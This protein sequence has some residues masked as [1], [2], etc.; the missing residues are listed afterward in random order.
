MTEHIGVGDVR[1]RAVALTGLDAASQF[2]GLCC[3]PRRAEV[4]VVVA[5]VADRFRTDAA[6]PHIAVGRDLCGG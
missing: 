3:G 5:Q 2:V 4:V 1:Q 6:G